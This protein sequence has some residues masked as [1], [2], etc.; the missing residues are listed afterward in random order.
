MPVITFLCVLSH[1]SAI[2]PTADFSSYPGLAPGAEFCRPLKRAARAGR[3][4]RI[5][6]RLKP[7]GI[8]RRIRGTEVPHYLVAPAAGAGCG[9][10]CDGG[11]GW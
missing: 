11:H 8:L 4:T 3:A 6:Q 5:P 10:A 1:V 2:Q 7:S 9:A